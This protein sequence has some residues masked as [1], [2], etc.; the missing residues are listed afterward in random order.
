VH[1]DV[2]AAGHELGRLIAGGGLLATGERQR[3]KEQHECKTI[4]GWGFRRLSQASPAPGPKRAVVKAFA[5]LLAWFALTSALAL[6]AP[7]PAPPAPG[8]SPGAAAM[9]GYRPHIPNTAQH[10]E[11][12]LEVNAKGQVSKIRSAQ[13]SHDLLFDKMTYGN[14]IQTFIRT[15]DGHAV[16]GVYRM[17]YDFN[18]KTQKIRRTVALIH[19]G[20]VDP[21]AP[22]AVD[23]MAAMNIHNAG[24]LRK[25]LQAQAH[26]AKASPVPTHKP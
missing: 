25:A 15:P 12:V 17:S 14:V 8:A 11:F 19:A 4:H 7:T 3:R 1:H 24:V 6:A 26:K 9:S 21:K 22:G 10:T 23:R 18:P 2:V 13:R 20:G 16:S 5:A